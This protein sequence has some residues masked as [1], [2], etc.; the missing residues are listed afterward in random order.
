MFNPIFWSY[1]FISTVKFS[2]QCITAG[3]V[4]SAAESWDDSV[5][6]FAWVACQ[7]VDSEH[8]VACS[9]MYPVCHAAAV[10]GLASYC[11]HLLFPC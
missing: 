3:F 1:K 11:Q 9:Q 7:A 5:V 6:C 8:F 10:A 2:H 4:A